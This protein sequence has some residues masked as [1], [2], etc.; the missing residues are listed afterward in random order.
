MISLK[1]NMKCDRCKLEQNEI[2]ILRKDKF[3][4]SGKKKKIYHRVCFSCAKWL[5][6]LNL[7]DFGLFWSQMFLDFG[8]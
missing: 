7:Y 1:S 4:K 6:K 2:I 8:G 5:I 3:I